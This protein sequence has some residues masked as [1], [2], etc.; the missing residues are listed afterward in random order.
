MFSEYLNRLVFAVYISIWL[1]LPIRKQSI[2]NCRSVVAWKGNF[3]NN[4]GPISCKMWLY[5]GISVL[6]KSTR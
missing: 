5:I 4:V 2:W 6:S 1:H 3:V